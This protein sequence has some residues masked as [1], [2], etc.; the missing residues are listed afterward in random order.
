MH[1]EEYKVLKAWQDEAKAAQAGIWGVENRPASPEEPK[2][3]CASSNS[4]TYHRSEC[5]IAKRISAANRHYYATLDEAESAGLKPCA[6]CL[7][8]K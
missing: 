5:N 2:P 8:K 7:G 1:G 6:R 4:K 3:F